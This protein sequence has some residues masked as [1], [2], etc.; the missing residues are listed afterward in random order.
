[1]IDIE[2]AAR[3]LLPAWQNHQSIQAI[4]ADCRPQTRSDGYAI[5]AA[6]VRASNDLPI[7]W[8]IA[9]T[10]SA[11]QA[12]LDVSGPL[13]GRLVAS[14]CL[15]DGATVPMIGNIM[16]VAEAEFA[17]RMKSDVTSDM[18]K[19]LDMQEVMSAVDTM[20]LAIEIPNSRYADFP[21]AGEAQLI[22][23]C[24]AACFVV[25]GPKIDIDWRAIDLKNH[26]VRLYIDGNVA[27][28]G[29]GGNVLGDPRLALTWIANELI[30]HGKKLSAGDVIITGTSIVPAPIAP[31]NSLRA[32]FGVLGSVRARIG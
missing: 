10:S 18:A 2:R 31:G 12:H 23:D 9:A 11:G 13:A 16:Q 20:H 8:K 29:K 30:S 15:E 7:G 14:R 1:M 25:L 17:F 32:D 26:E 3:S 24:A 4:P 28:V 19:P 22:A 6:L 21:K 5:Q 27:A